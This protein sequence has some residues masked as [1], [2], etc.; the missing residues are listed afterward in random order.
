VLADQSRHSLE[1]DS[2]IRELASMLGLHTAIGLAP[3][4]EM[5]LAEFAEMGMALHQQLPMK[6]PAVMPIMRFSPISSDTW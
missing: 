1:S 2:Q 3:F 6:R 4:V 5:L